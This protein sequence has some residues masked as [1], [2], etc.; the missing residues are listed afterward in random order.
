MGVIGAAVATM[1]ANTTG[2]FVGGY[3]LFTGKVGIHLTRELLKPDWSLYYKILRVGLPSSADAMTMDFGS[4][5]LARIIYTPGTQYGNPDV[6]FA[7][8]SIA[9]KL[10]GVMSAVLISI[11]AA[12]G[13]MIGQ[14]IGAELYDRAKK[15]A[16]T[17][18]LLNFAILRVGAAALGVSEKVAFHIQRGS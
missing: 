13:T 15:I 3:L 8:Y 9:D 16:G 11:S 7:T 17:A 14:S 6:V 18:M 2:A 1:L 4:V 12:M 10:V 5:L